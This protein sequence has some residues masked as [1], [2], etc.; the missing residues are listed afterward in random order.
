MNLL[1]ALLLAA[2]FLTPLGMLA[3]MA[4]PRLRARIP[5]LLALA[6]LPGLAAALLAEGHGLVFLAEGMRLGLALDRP[7]ALLLGVA[8]LLWSA[9][10]AYAGAYMGQKP[11]FT[12]FAG[13]WLL[14]LSGSLGVFVAGDLLSFYLAFALVSLPAYGLIVHDGTPAARRAGS[15]TLFLAVLGEVCLLLG[16][17]LL[18]VGTPGLSIAIADAVASLPSSPWRNAAV[19]LLLAGFGLKAGM[20]PLHVWLPLA[21]PAA[22]MPA[23]AVLSGAIIKAGIIGLIRFLPVDGALADWG[24]VLGVLGFVT[25]FWGVALGITQQNPK[26]VLAYSS[27]SQMGVVLAALGLGLAA[28]E[29]VTPISAAFYAAHH[30]LAKGA[31][32]LALGVALHLGRARFGWVFWP[33]LVLVLGFGGLPLTGGWL[34]KA[35]TKAQ[36]GTGLASVLA[37]LSAA[38]S[39]LL[40]LHFLARL[41][42]GLGEPA[43]GPVPRGMLLPWAGM[44]ATAVLIPWALFVPSGAGS[45]AE[46]FKPEALAAA[47]WPV[48]LG[49]A[50]A[51]ALARWGA[52][53]PQPPEGDVLA[54]AERA[55]GRAAGPASLAADRIEARLRTWPAAS[56]A[57]LGLVIACAAVMLAAIPG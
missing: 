20:V 1:A 11:G 12:R 27:I 53:L 22:P 25:A 17:V 36:L 49:A 33:A 42:A 19:G 6:P 47:L 51:W 41:R 54:L 29:A 5:F 23:S 13:W 2:T 4:H 37:A 8:A 55:F 44:T 16:F 57:L 46:A 45:F 43:A 7:S 24:V 35:A 40:M 31:L 38:G 34:A 18:A 48:L 9:A 50:L 52:G 39:T 30:V 21:H 10:G 28:G 26:A 15:V 3:A 14:T 56:L 32:F